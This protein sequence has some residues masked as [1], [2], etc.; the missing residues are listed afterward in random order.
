[1]TAVRKKK[2]TQQHPLLLP[3]LKPRNPLVAPA[4]QRKAGAH[5]TALTLKS[6]ERE[7]ARRAIERSLREEVKIK[8][9]AKRHKN[10]P[11]D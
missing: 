2:L 7:T 8:S 1:M 6:K 11:H 9:A 3:A 4:L 10:L 5:H